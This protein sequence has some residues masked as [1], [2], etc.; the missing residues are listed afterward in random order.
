MLAA[1]AGGTQRFV[2]TRLPFFME[3]EANARLA[4]EVHRPKAP[5]AFFP[6]LNIRDTGSDGVARVLPL[7]G[8]GVVEGFVARRLG[9]AGGTEAEEAV[10]LSVAF[11]A[12][13]PCS[14]P[15]TGASNP[16][17]SWRRALL[18]PQ[19]NPGSRYRCGEGLSP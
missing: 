8:D 3:S 6:Y 17:C 5:F 7:S 2:D 11:H 16:S 9:L 13:Q 1:A 10:C 19:V 4:A 15:L 18:M 14:P 12:L